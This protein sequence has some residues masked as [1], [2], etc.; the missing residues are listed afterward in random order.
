MFS[1]LFLTES[2]ALLMGGC[3]FVYVCRGSVVCFAV[4]F[5]FLIDICLWLF[6]SCLCLPYMQLVFSCET[7]SFS[8]QHSGLLF[9][10]PF[11]RFFILG[12]W[13]MRRVQ[14]LFFSAESSPTQIH[15]AAGPQRCIFFVAFARVAAP[16]FPSLFTLATSCFSFCCQKIRTLQASVH[17]N[18]SF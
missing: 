7:C 8:C 14:S 12:G 4:A 6:F 13:S 18:V 11:P 5:L 1:A 17:S 15:E 2:F 16:L 3:C 10:S 9:L